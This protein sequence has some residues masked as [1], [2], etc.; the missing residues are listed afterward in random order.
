MDRKLGKVLALVLLLSGLA[1]A[2]FP[3]YASRG[4]GSSGVTSVTI[5]G[6]TNEVT[7]TGTCH[8]TSTGT[9]TLSLPTPIAIPSSAQFGSSAGD[10]ISFD[11][12]LSDGFYL[13]DDTGDNV[14]QGG[15]SI[16]LQLANSNGP[17]FNLSDS[18]GDQLFSLA[19]GAGT[20]I[21]TDGSANLNILATSIGAPGNGTIVL[22]SGTGVSPNSLT[23][24][25]TGAGFT[26][27]A[28]NMEINAPN[29]YLSF[30]NVIGMQDNS[31]GQ[32]SGVATIAMGSN[33]VNVTFPV[34]YTGTNPPVIVATP[35]A[36]SSSLTLV[37][38]V[39]PV[40]G[41]GDWTG[42]AIAVPSALATAANFNWIAMGQ[43]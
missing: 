27:N 11:I 29:G 21:S 20:T 34:T 30:A 37:P 38:A 31:G 5:D 35:V 41:S 7:V 16:G 32:I 6:T 15:D 42:F 1:A 2:Q 43:P 24:S 18:S 9:C 13:T 26:V 28:G 22:Q 12:D 25:E 36:G 10:Y 14:V 23:I 40:G 8:I 33:G 3:R 39:I 17:Q 4:G 19:D